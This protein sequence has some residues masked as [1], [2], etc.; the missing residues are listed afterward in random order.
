MDIH[1]PRNGAALEELGSYSPEVNQDGKI[2]NLKADRVKYWLSVGAQP[3]ETAAS[4]LRKSG[5]EIP[6][7]AKHTR[8]RPKR[9]KAAEGGE[10]KA[11]AAPA[12]GS[13]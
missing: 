1:T 3:T 11:E 9:E 6:G 4:L 5:I 13:A 7:W 10:A 12:E 2:V 8:R